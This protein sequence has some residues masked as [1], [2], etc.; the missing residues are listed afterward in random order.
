MG[1]DSNPR[2]PFGAHTLS[3]RARST[4]PAPIHCLR[5]GH[6]GGSA[7][8]FQEEMYVRGGGMRRCHSRF[9]TRRDTE[10]VKGG[11]MSCWRGQ[12]GRLPTIRF[13]YHGFERMTRI[14]RMGRRGARRWRVAR[15]KDLKSIRVIRVIRSNPWLVFLG[16]SP[17]FHL[18]QLQSLSLFFPPSEAYG[19]R[20]VGQKGRAKCDMR[21]DS[22]T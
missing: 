13:F 22:G 5:A 18:G 6:N 8:E 4:T 10:V 15:P 17:A 21:L 2:S 11:F 1:R 3:R 16:S 12:R 19:R 20:K 9:S 14:T 7:P